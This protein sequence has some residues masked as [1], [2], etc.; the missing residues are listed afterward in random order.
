MR[1]LGGEAPVHRGSVGV[2]PLLPCGDLGAQRLLI[3]DA[4][5]EALA[6]KDAE[7]DL[8]DVQ[9][10]AVLGGVVEIQP[11]EDVLGLC[12]RERLVEGGGA[13]RVEVVEHD[14]DAGGGR[15]KSSSTI[16]CIR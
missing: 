11:T 14:I 7:L 13:V 3:G 1:I 2:A 5:I 4:P 12:G 15:G 6:L 10:T 8:R 16:L 9:P